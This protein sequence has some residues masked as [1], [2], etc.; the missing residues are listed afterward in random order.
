MRQILLPSTNN[1][2]AGTH[3]CGIAKT[4]RIVNGKWEIVNGMLMLHLRLLLLCTSIPS[5]WPPSL[6]VGKGVPHDDRVILQLEESV[7]KRARQ[8]PFVALLSTEP[9]CC[10]MVGVHR[11][12]AVLGN[13]HLDV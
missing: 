12:L 5:T 10:G 11:V 2:V 9:S 4:G 3:Q 7:D 1:L 8:G 13:D 6:T